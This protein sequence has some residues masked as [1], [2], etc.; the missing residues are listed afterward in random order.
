ML[1]RLLRRVPNGSSGLPW[2]SAF[3]ATWILGLLSWL[4]WPIR[5]FSAK[6][7]P[8]EEPQGAQQ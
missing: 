8:A 6:G 3:S 1:L 7:A 2:R 5:V 4:C